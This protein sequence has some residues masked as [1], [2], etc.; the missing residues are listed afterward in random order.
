MP[1]A[2]VLYACD[3]SWWNHHRGVPEFQGEK[4]SSHSSGVNE[5][6]ST[7]VAER[8]GLRIVQGANNKG[9]SYDPNLIHYGRNS[10]F[11]AINLA[12]HFGCDRI[13]LVGFDMNFGYGLHFFG[14]HPPGLHRNSD[15]SQ[16]VK[17]FKPAAESLPPGIRVVNATPGSGLKHF[18]MM[19]LTSAL[20]L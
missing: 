11:Q 15:H 9:F 3:N 12:I 10:G 18:P 8:W 20:L 5:K 13:V 2:K 1:Y 4:W 14:D 7:G 19:D 6:F 17:E 16:F